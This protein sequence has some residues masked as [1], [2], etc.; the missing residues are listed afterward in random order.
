MSGSTQRAL[1][2][3]DT[4]V[5]PVVW[6]LAA[7]YGDRTWV[8]LLGLAVGAVTFVVWTVAKVQLGPSFTVGAQ[9]REL[10]TRG[11]YARFRHPIYLFGGLAVSGAIVA[12]QSWVAVIVWLLLIVPLQVTRSGREDRLLEESFGPQYR[13]YRSKTWL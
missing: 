4:A 1:Y 13:A 11:L 8:W 10:V 12:F 6:G 9:A 3:S 7:R 2:W 5:F